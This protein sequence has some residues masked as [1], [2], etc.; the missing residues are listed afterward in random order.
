MKDDVEYAWPVL[1]RDA[2]KELERLDSY[3]RVTA[4][5]ESDAD[6]SAHLGK[7]VGIDERR[8]GVSVYECIE[9]YLAEIFSDLGDVGFSDEHAAAKAKE[10]V[11]FFRLDSIVFEC[12]ALVENL[13]CPMDQVDL[14]DG[15]VIRRTTPDERSGL[16]ERMDLSLSYHDAHTLMRGSE[17]VLAVTTEESKLIHDKD[18]ASSGGVE[19]SRAVHRHF[20]AA[21]AALSVF[22]SAR[23]TYHRISRIAKTWVPGGREFH[24]GHPGVDP[25][26]G[27][28]TRD[29]SSAEIEEFLDF[30]P[31]FQKTGEALRVGIRWLNHLLGSP[32]TPEDHV[33]RAAIVLESTLLHG[34]GD[35][36]KYRLRL[37]G[38]RVLGD[39]PRQDT[40]EILGAL[41]DY[42]SRVVHDGLSLPEKISIGGCDLNRSEFVHRLT[43]ICR[44]VVVSLIE[45]EASGTPLAKALQELDEEALLGTSSELGERSN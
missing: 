36:L 27:G 1:I 25:L 4:W 39:R 11:S 5:L 10:F 42:R 7:M 13:I 35:E 41:Y 44:D 29:F 2:R 21:C 30:W 6:S 37:R 20:S 26:I 3:R 22:G 38:A 28:D 15:L 33:V 8:H 23:I 45:V 9:S 24:P 32:G 31:N 17:F 12:T 18:D 19:S 16:L 40:Y 14:E 43:A 34:T